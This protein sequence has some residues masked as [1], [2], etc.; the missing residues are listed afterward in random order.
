MLILFAIGIMLWLIYGIMIQELPIIIANGATFFL[1][2]V[3]VI[4]KFRFD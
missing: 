3:I 2:M 1:V 4:L